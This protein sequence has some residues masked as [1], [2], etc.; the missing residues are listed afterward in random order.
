MIQ[1]N[2]KPGTKRP[3]K[4]KKQRA[5]FTP[6]QHALHRR[7]A[8]EAAA[9]QKNPGLFLYDDVPELAALLEAALAEIKGRTRM[10]RRVIF[11][12]EG[13]TYA[14]AIIGFDPVQVENRWT[15]DFIAQTS[16]F[17]L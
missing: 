16:I 7:I 17:R 9:T 2:K 11:K 13:R 6:R 8:E 12:H 10:T 1:S 14:A 15:G 4:A 3:G 5:Y